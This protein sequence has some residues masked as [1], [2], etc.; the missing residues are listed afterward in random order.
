MVILATLAARHNE[1]LLYIKT[2]AACNLAQTSNKLVYQ[3]PAKSAAD[4]LIMRPVPPS[5]PLSHSPCLLPSP[6]QLAYGG[7][8]SLLAQSRASKPT[9]NWQAAINDG[10]PTAAESGQQ[11]GQTLTH[12]LRTNLIQSNSVVEVQTV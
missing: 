12:S 3:Q 7:V 10:P 6:S 2:R 9:S 11:Q 5:L 1:Y 4:E 8:W